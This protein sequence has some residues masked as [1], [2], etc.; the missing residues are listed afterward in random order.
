MTKYA[1]IESG[2]KQYK[3][4]KGDVVKL[5]L[6]ASESQ[7]IQFDKV[8]LVFDTEGNTFEIGTPYLPKV[9]VEAK[10]LE[11]GK[12]KKVRVLKFKPKVRS[13]KLYGHR[14]PYTKVQIVDIV[15]SH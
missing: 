12:S 4:K 1:I 15:E 8:L 2:G 10:I 7:A 5:E 3:I 9:H 14:Q 11:T 6:L 13:K